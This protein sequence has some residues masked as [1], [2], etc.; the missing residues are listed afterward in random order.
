MLRGEEE[1][2]TPTPFLKFFLRLGGCSF[3]LDPEV[4]RFAVHLIVGEIGVLDGLGHN[5]LHVAVGA[6]LKKSALGHVGGGS[7][8]KSPRLEAAALAVKFLAL[9]AGNG[10]D[11]P[12]A[13]DRFSEELDA[14][15]KDKGTERMASVSLSTSKLTQL[16]DEHDLY[17]CSG[18]LAVRKPIGLLFRSESLAEKRIPNKVSP[19]LL[20]AFGLDFSVLGFSRPWTS[21]PGFFE[22]P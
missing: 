1:N 3:A 18:S 5:G 7:G 17:P 13:V 19:R 20:G 11:K 2:S 8:R 9:V 16:V 21:C 4:D 14:V 6:A 12:K 10:I 22:T 15:R